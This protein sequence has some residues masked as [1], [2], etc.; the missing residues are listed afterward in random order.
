M[1]SLPWPASAAQHLVPRRRRVR[2]GEDIRQV[3][4]VSII[5]QPDD[6]PGAIRRPGPRAV[7]RRPLARR[8]RAPQLR[9]PA[10]AAAAAVAR[11]H[12]HVPPAAGR[13]WCRA[14]REGAVPGPSLD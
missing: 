8:V 1:T 4:T 11:R 12:A 6:G 10:A 14:V 5:S 3:T 2:Q 13:I 9:E 7:G